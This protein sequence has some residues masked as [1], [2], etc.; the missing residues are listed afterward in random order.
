MIGDKNKT[1]VYPYKYNSHQFF[2]GNQGWELLT[3]KQFQPT[4]EYEDWGN[5]IYV[6]KRKKIAEES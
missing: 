6:F 3:V 5:E 2:I 4:K 1:N